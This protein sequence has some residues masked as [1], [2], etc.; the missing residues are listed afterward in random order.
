MPGRGGRLDDIIGPVYVGSHLVQRGSGIGSFLSSLFRIVKPL[1]ASRAGA[2]GRETLRAGANIISDRANKSSGTKVKNIISNRAK[3]ST[4][5]RVDKLKGLGKKRGQPSPP[6][7]PPPAK[8]AK[9]KKNEYR[10]I[11]S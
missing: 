10:D 7:P 9:R 4:Q 11:F 3:E 1:P 2:V 6:P 5:S 8:K